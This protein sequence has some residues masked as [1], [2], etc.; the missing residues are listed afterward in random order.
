ME[1]KQSKRNS[2]LQQLGE[3]V[4]LVD[5]HSEYITKIKAELDSDPPPE[6]RSEFKRW[7]QK[8][9]VKVDKQIAEAMK[10][11]K[12]IPAYIPEPEKVGRERDWSATF[13]AW[14]AIKSE[15]PIT[16]DDLAMKFNFHPQTVRRA[17]A[18]YKKQ[19]HREATNM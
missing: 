8:Q 16:L 4:T 5:H 18:R 1:E 13:E 14:D 19:H 17:H 12:S 6:D 11:W 9:K 3:K 7:A 15:I 2:I 10:K